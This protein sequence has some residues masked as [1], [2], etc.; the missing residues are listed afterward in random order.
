VKRKAT[1]GRQ[2]LW[3]KMQGKIG[4]PIRRDQQGQP[5]VGAN[6]KGGRL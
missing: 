3:F 2:T 1:P 4:I 5:P 6:F